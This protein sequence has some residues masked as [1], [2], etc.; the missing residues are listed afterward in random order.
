MHDLGL[1]RAESPEQLGLSSERLERISMTFRHDVDCGLIPGAVLLIARG[2][3]IGYA[4][5]FG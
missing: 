5:A 3:Q 1:P 4:E 2:G